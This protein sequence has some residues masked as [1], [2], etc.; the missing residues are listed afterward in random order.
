[1]GKITKDMIIAEVLG[2]YPETVPVFKNAGIQ[3][4]GCASAV[5]ETVEQAA[6]VHGLDP[7][8]F[9]KKLNEAVKE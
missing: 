5:G 1:M 2:R 9:L 8:E 7:E 4:L 6:Q 3:C